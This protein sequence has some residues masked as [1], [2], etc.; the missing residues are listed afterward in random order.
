MAKKKQTVD[1]PV[2]E[3][4]DKQLDLFQ[5]ELIELINETGAVE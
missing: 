3:L 2:E 5:D 1:V 4:T